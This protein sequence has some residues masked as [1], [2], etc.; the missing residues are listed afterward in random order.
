MPEFWLLWT[1]ATWG[2]QREASILRRSDLPRTAYGVHFTHQV[3]LGAL[4][5]LA[6]IVPQ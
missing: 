2:M 4:L 3:M 5:L 1:A 6:L